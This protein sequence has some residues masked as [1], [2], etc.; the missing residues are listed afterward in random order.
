MV[1]STHDQKA[2]QTADRARHDHGAD[3][4]LSHVDTDVARGV[5][6]LAH[7]ADL[8]SVL[9]VIQIDVH[10]SRQ[11][12]GHEDQ[13]QIL[14]EDHGQMSKRQTRQDASVAGAPFCEAKRHKS[15]SNVVHHQGKQRF[16][17]V[18]LCLKDCGQST[19][20]SARQHSGCKHDQQEC[21]LGDLAAQIIGNRNRC[22]RTDQGLPLCTDI[23]KAHTERGGDRQ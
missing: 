8:I 18:P 12:Q 23:P 6:A 21:G 2:C 9:G 11:S 20:N 19:P 15:C 13:K 14:I 7:H 3:D 5:F 4:N 17:G 1:Q 22:K 10:H 16:V